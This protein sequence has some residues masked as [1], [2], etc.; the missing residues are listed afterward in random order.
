MRTRLPTIVAGT[1]LAVIIAV[2]VYLVAGLYNMKKAS[3][4]ES[5]RRTLLDGYIGYGNLPDD[6]G[7]GDAYY[8]LDMLAVDLMDD[9]FLTQKDSSRLLLNERVIRQ[10]ESIL[11]AGD[12]L[13]PY[14]KNY[15]Q[16]HGLDTV[17]S[18][19]ILL[20]GL[21]FL[22]PEGEIAVLPS[23]H[24]PE[25]LNG[26]KSFFLL[27]NYHT[28]LDFSRLSFGY[29]IDV[30]Q[31]QRTI[32]RQMTAALF[33]SLLSVLI[34]A[35]I[36]FVTLRN[37]MRHQQLSMMKTDFI[38]NMAHELKTPLTIISVAGSTL[39][40]E[41]VQKEPEQVARLTTLIRQQNKHLGR[42]I[43][44]L[45]DINVWERDQITL[46]RKEVILRDMLER[47]LEA[48]RLEYKDKKFKLES[49]LYLDEQT[50][51][52]ADEFQLSV[53]LRNLL[54]NALKY[55]GDPPQVRVTARIEHEQLQ[56]EVADNGAGIPPGE[57]EQVFEKFFRGK[58][59][60]RQAKGLGLGLFYVKKIIDMHGGSVGIKK[61]TSQ[62]TTFVITIPQ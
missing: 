25:F 13:T 8:D 2:Q 46:D 45:L 39:A 38:N 33:L 56:I 16:H 41:E 29:Y 30:T 40:G 9:Y 50:T 10:A 1:A 19:R 59:S 51:G 42:L 61:S 15:L 18:T 35:V 21:T 27:N 55:G 31:K 14:L 37:L 3:L 12:R 34:T 47:I 17:F 26:R 48:F 54:S 58:S 49:Q 11:T 20:A 4:E 43:D 28:E 6:T 62:G 36:F 44:Q 22:Y 7:F 23:R 57:V 52:K 5:Y 32:L 60:Q 24:L 53:A